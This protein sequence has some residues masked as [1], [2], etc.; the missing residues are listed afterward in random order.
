MAQGLSPADAARL[1]PPCALAHVPGCES[2][3]LPD[4]VRILHGGT[5]NTSLRVDTHRGRFVMRLNDA[6]GES[7]G[8]DHDREA[9]LQAAA[10]LGGVAPK[11][12]YA[13]PN[14]RFMVMCYIDGPTW[15]P[16]DFG[17][18]ERLRTLGRT[19][20][21]LHAIEPPPLMP[22]DL[23]A[24]LRGYSAQLAAAA[25]AERG[26]LD[27]LMES[28]DRSLRLCKSGARPQC[29]VHND[30]HHSNLIGGERLYL[31]DWE[32]AAVA[33]PIFDVA[34]ILAYYPAAEQHAH[35]LLVASGLAEVVSGAELEGASSL[36]VHLSFLWYRLRRLTFTGEVADTAAESALLQRLRV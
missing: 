15:D 12:I 14:R 20:L 33:D 35:E 26:L 25:P 6:A 8:A 16:P 34:C 30:L 18:S 13:D 36:F 9:I 27:G 3:V 28:A 4:A 1:I 29:I 24:I 10:A 23:G 5:V 2:G 11:L 31:I 22:F 21:R 17:R 19:L 32:Y 7:L